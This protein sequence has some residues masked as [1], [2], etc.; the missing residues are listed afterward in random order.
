MSAERHRPAF[1]RLRRTMISN[2][3]C[4]GVDIVTVQKIAGHANVQTTAKYDRRGEEAKRKAAGFLDIG[5]DAARRMPSGSDG[6]SGAQSVR[7]LKPVFHKRICFK[8]LPPSLY[9]SV[10]I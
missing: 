6:P 3:P 4:V 2:L 5:S 10:I 7:C 1:T 9:T 8:G